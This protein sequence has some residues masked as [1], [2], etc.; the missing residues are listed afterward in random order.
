MGGS[1][2]PGTVRGRAW[3]KQDLEAAGLNH[4]G[5]QQPQ[6]EYRVNLVAKSV[7]KERGSA[8][9]IHPGPQ[10]CSSHGENFLTVVTEVLGSK[11][12]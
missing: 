10:G 8:L 7:I 9:Q 2:V 1:Y 6:R 11:T 3:R 4:R 5:L 12:H